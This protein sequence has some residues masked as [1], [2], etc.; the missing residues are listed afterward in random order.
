MNGHFK[1][2]I[3]RKAIPLKEQQTIQ[4]FL[5]THPHN[6]SFQSPEWFHFYLSLPNYKPLY[7]SITDESGLVKAVMLAVIIAEGSGLMAFVSSRCVIYGGPIIDQD[8]DVILATLLETLTRQMKSKAIFTQFRNFRYWNQ[9]S[10]SI[11]EKHGYKLRD[12]LNL[13]VPLES[14]DKVL[15]AFSASRRRQLK[16][17]LAARPEIRQAVSLKEVKDFYEMLHKLYKT[18][19]KKPLPPLTFFDHFYEK[20]VPVG[21]GVI[22]LVFHQ[23]QLIGGIICPLTPGHTIAELYVCGLD[24]AFPHLYPSVLAT[25]AALDYGIQHRIPE[26]DFMGLGKPEKA[27]GVRD[28]KLRFGGNQVNFGRFARRN[29]KTLY[30]IAE[31]GYNILRSF[32]RI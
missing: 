17:A 24:K 13:I 27:Y 28:F 18:R 25:W 20:L 31:L 32:Q 29:N 11:F 1:L 9:S 6:T 3:Y 2:T 23:N 10:V 15:S 21:Q 5:S 12:R 14:A 16:K 8:N 19:V 30:A 7:F 26:F 4:Q 22:L